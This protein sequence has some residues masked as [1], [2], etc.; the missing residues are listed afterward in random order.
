MTA[1]NFITR[2]VPAR[3]TV[4]ALAIMIDHCVVRIP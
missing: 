4:I 2:M 3:T 1:R